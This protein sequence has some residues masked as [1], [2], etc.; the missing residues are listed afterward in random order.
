MENTEIC[1]RCGGACCKAGGAHIF[2]DELS[3]DINEENLINLLHKGFYSIDYWG[4]PPTDNSDNASRIFYLRY[5]HTGKE[6][7]LDHSKYLPCIMLN[8]NGCRLSH[9]ER[10]K[11]C[12][13]LVPKEDFRCN[14]ENGELSVVSCALSWQKYQNELIRALKYFEQI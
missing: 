8:E 14:Y 13:E 5:S 4:T 6:T 1:Y 9:N 10:P 7:L 12:R 11:V 2:P 3:F